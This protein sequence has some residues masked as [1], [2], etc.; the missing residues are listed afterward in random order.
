MV[1]GGLTDAT[2]ERKLF[3]AHVLNGHYY[4]QRSTGRIEDPVALVQAMIDRGAV[5][6]TTAARTDYLLLESA[7][8]VRARLTSGK[9]A[10]LELVKDDVARDALGLI[11]MALRDESGPAPAD[12]VDALWLPGSYTLPE[13]DR[14]RLPEVAGAEQEVV[15]SVVERLRTHAGA[16][17]ALRRRLR[18]EELVP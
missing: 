1:S 15:V 10:Y 3:V 16:R 5:G 13:R 18:G 12:G 11:A 8:I 9:R 2:H 17:E 4:G 14:M 7:G 6:P